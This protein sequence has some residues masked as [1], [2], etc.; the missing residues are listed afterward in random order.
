[1]ETKEN[2][3]QNASLLTTS[4]HD[5]AELLSPKPKIKK[6]NGVLRDITNHQD[7]L[8]NTPT[9]NNES[10]K[11]YEDWDE[12]FQEE[13]VDTENHPMDISNNEVVA[14]DDT[15]TLLTPCKEDSYVETPSFVKVT[16]KLSPESAKKYTTPSHPFFQ[17]DMP[18]LNDS[19]WKFTFED[20]NT[21]LDQNVKLIS[22]NL[23][24][25]L[26]S[27]LQKLLKSISKDTILDNVSILHNAL[28]NERKLRL[29]KE[30]EN[31][32]FW[33]LILIWRNIT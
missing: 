21:L 28:V 31:G 32:K 1:M 17:Q 2:N 10:I 8:T 30:E 22:A 29:Q 14:S 11:L 19:K 23:R 16:D 20:F 12:L 7:I 26:E 13:Q 15:E 18:G 25:V 33:I 4:A 6:S 3:P 24:K 27:D 5:L 9:K